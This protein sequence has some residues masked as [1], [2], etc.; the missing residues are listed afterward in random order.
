MN[1][2]LGGVDKSRRIDYNENEMYYH[3]QE[4][5]H[6]ETSLVKWQARRQRS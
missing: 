2:G 5:N 6:G 1:L 4:A 3:S